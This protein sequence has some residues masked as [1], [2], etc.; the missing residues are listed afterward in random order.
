MA[1]NTHV[2]T[3]G[4]RSAALELSATIARC[5][6]FD[7]APPYPG[8]C[9]D[10]NSIDLSS[11]VRDDQD[12]RTV[13]KDESRRRANVRC[14]QLGRRTAEKGGTGIAQVKSGGI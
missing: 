12:G 11:A 3:A 5:R 7:T 1:T 10:D 2:P 4:K 9:V 14:T 6:T 13:R 8:N